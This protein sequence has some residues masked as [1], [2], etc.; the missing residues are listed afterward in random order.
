MQ[1]IKIG[2]DNSNKIVINNPAVSSLHAELTVLNNGDLLLEDKGCLNGTTVNGQPI[3]PG[4]QVP[5][6]RGDRIAF[7]GQELNW[8]SVPQP[9]DLSKYSAIFGVGSAYQN[10]VRLTGSHVSRYHATIKKTKD[11]KWMIEDHSKNGTTI[12][13]QRIPAGQNVPIKR[14]DVI[15]C[16]GN[17]LDLSTIMPKPRFNWNVAGWVAGVVALLAVGIWTW[18]WSHDQQEVDRTTAC[19]FHRF[20][21]VVTLD[22][23]PFVQL[24]HDLG[25]DD[26]PDKYE[27]GIDSKGEVVAVGQTAEIFSEK[28]KGTPATI[29]G[30][31]FYVDNEGKMMT[32]RHVVAPWEVDEEMQRKVQEKMGEYQQEFV[33]YGILDFLVTRKKKAYDT[34][35]IQAAKNRYLSS[36]IEVSGTTDFLG[37]APAYQ[38]LDGFDELL[39]ANVVNLSKS[40]DIDLAILQLNVRK[41][42]DDVKPHVVDIHKAIK[43]QDLKP[44]KSK[45]T[46][47]GYPAGPALNLDN[48]NN[49]GLTPTAYEIGLSRRPDKYEME[50]QGQVLGG[51]S[52]SPIITQDGLF[53]GVINKAIPGTTISKGVLA[54]HAVELYD[55]TIR[56]EAN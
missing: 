17:T 4:Q 46:Y 27:F 51:A 24:F 8:M 47:Y 20:H 37:V 41:T 45:F 10:D 7:A 25:L 42:P 36:K 43:A 32:N 39:K 19:V 31:A 38:L 52:G 30:T 40:K 18:P 13:G 56:Q 54:K 12:N 15:T 9:E 48:K 26:W 55:E 50:L 44:G 1:L 28:A 35:A 21:Y 5:V 11:G 34:N 53:A 3:Q 2:R 49:V 22:N 14:K 33:N 23:D 29:T 16:G 6:R